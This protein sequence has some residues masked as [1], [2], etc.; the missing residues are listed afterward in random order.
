MRSWPDGSDAA[1]CRPPAGI[2]LCFQAFRCRYTQEFEGIRAGH[3]GAAVMA[4]CTVIPLSRTE[5]NRPFRAA[6]GILSLLQAAADLPAG[7]NE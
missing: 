4:A 5:A 1:G 2:S 3:S 6:A 7:K